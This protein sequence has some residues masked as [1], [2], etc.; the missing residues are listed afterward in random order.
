MN[1]M[2]H[3]AFGCRDKAAM[4]KFYTE[5]F[6]FRRA[7]VFNPGDPGE[8]V[9]LR[10]G[11]MCIELFLNPDA[12]ADATGGEQTVGY[13]HLAFLVPSLKAKIAELKTAGI[14]SEDIIDCSG[15]SPGMRVCFFHDPEGNYVELME[16]WADEENPPQ[17]A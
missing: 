2:G 16:N 5:Q 13:R 8:F 12:P 1:V 9:V 17:M 10:L 14:T 15:I 6:G 11:A 7:R 3:I 4:E